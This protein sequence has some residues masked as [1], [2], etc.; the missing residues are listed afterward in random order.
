MAKTST[1][2]S[3][4]LR[5]NTARIE[6]V[7]TFELKAALEKICAHSGKNAS[8]VVRNM[9]INEYRERFDVEIAAE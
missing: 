8:G 9:I 2:R 7:L 6:I 1:Q 3:R 4:E 5:K